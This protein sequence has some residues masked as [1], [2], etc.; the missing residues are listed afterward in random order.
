MFQTSNNQMLCYVVKINSKYHCSIGWQL[1]GTSDNFYL[2]IMFFPLQGRLN[3]NINVD[4]S[5]VLQKMVRH[6]HQRFTQLVIGFSMWFLPNL[7]FISTF[8]LIRRLLY[9]DV[10]SE[11]STMEVIIKLMFNCIIKAYHLHSIS[12]TWYNIL[13][14]HTGCYKQIVSKYP[15]KNFNTIIFQYYY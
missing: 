15:A 1:E 12:N 9:S 7:F 8:F 5:F 3:F 2:D 13:V 14:L 10:F 6:L 4:I 11:L